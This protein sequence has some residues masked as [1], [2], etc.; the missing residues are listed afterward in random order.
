MGGGSP[1][2][3]PTRTRRA[4]QTEYVYVYGEQM[5]VVPA[6]TRDADLRRL[7]DREAEADDFRR[8]AGERE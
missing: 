8:A 6:G 1:H 4:C 2:G 5:S 7:A 3:S